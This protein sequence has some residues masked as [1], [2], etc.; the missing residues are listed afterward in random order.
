MRGTHRELCSM[1]VSNGERGGEK[2]G[3]R[4]DEREEW[5]DG[6]GENAT[7]GEWSGPSSKKGKEEEDAVYKI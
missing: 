1:K 7:E 6:D 3:K 5:R 2:I 4:K